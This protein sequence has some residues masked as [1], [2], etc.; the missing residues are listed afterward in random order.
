MKRFLTVVSKQF[1]MQ[2]YKDRNLSIYRMRF[3]TRMS[4]FLFK[5]L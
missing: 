5:N 1:E 4:E 2:A 3:Y